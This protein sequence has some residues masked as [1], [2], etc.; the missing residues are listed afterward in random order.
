MATLNELP[1]GQ[2]E[3]ENASPDSGRGVSGDKP[4]HSAMHWLV[5]VI[6][7]VCAG[8]AVFFFGWLPR[9]KRTESIN[10]EAKDRSQ[11]LPRVQV[12][13]VR[14]ALPTS[15][16]AVPGT[17]LPY[18]EAHIYARASGYV[19]L[20]LVDIGDHVRAGQLLATIDSPD[21]DR[22]VAQ[23]QAALQQ[24]EASLGQLRAQQHL[25]QVTWDRWKVL[26][27][28]GVF[29]RQEGDQ[30]EANYRVSEANVAAGENIVESNRENLNRLKVLQ[31]YERVTAPF[32]GVITARNI[33]VG[34]LISSNGTGL[35]AGSPTSTGG[36]SAAGV[37]GNNQGASG[38]LTSN[39]STSA[40]G[41]QGGEMF[42]IASVDRLRILVSVPEAYTSSIKVGE[43]AVLSFQERLNEQLKGRV[44]RTSASIN[45]NTRTLLVEVQ[46]ANN[47]KLVPGMYV[48]VSFRS[49]NDQPPIII[50]GAAIVIRDGKTS[51]AVVN[52][53]TIHIQP[54]TVGRDYG[55]LTEVTSGLRDGDAIALDV[56]DEIREGS[57]I[58][59]Q[60]A[61]TGNHQPGSQSE[62]QSK[63][64]GGGGSVGSHS[65]D[66]G[67]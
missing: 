8:L 58:D 6:L 62:P 50:P 60:F 28:R 19:A 13:R 65:S 55:E 14:R 54:I 29:S 20:R 39:V 23:A 22:Q 43:P 16:L 67:K 11:A 59:P 34:A 15:E 63:S 64:K 33:D 51:V 36:V 32:A 10:E 66:S 30:Q 21:L 18:T 52:G 49:T 25:A 47:G 46:V 26:V 9:H 35:G 56:T 24:S 2:A 37:Q 4:G 42:T 27:G 61:N 7:L 45:Q 48:S 44:T 5:F 31:E 17:T 57:K 41:A 53:Q 40:G 38:N 1:P 3:G 12:Q